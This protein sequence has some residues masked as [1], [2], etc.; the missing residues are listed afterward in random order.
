MEITTEQ[1]LAIRELQYK[2]ARLEK[3]YEVLQSQLKATVESMRTEAQFSTDVVFDL[4]ALAFR[5]KA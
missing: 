4:D 5:E 2:I 1:K 3:A